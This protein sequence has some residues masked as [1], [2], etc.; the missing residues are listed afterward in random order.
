VC[1]GMRG[2][3]L[4]KSRHVEIVQDAG[5]VI[6]TGGKENGGAGGKKGYM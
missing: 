6:N 1:Y 5:G 3:G 2:I 4:C